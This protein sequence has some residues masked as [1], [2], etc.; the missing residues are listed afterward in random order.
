MGKKSCP[1]VI[2][3]FIAVTYTFT[4]NIDI[5][6]TV[7]NREGE[8]VAG[9][10]VLLKN[11]NLNTTSVQDGSY[12]IYYNSTAV[13][14]PLP[15]DLLYEAILNNNFI[16]FKLNKPE[17][18]TLSIY[19]LDGRAISDLHSGYLSKGKYRFAFPLQ[20]LSYQVY[21]LR[22]GIGT[23]I[24]THKIIPIMN[25]FTL[26]HMG[27]ESG[28][29]TGNARKI[30]VD[31]TLIVACDKYE[32]K[33]VPVSEYIT[34][35]DIVLEFDWSDFL[36]PDIIFQNKYTSF[37]EFTQ[38]F[39]SIE[40]TAKAIAYGV[41]RKL[42]RKWSES[43]KLEQITFILDDDPNTIGWKS[44]HPP[45]IT[46][47]V[48]GPYLQNYMGNDIEKMADEVKGIMWHEYTHGYQYDDLPNTGGEIPA[49]VEG[50]ADA[51]R[52]FAGYIPISMRRPGGSWTYAYKTSAFFIAWI[53][54]E[55][56][57]GDPEFLYKFNQQL[58]LDDGKEFAW[59]TAIQE[60]LGE[61]VS[62]VWDKYQDAI[63]IDE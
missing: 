55:Y 52:Y 28:N 7:L 23:D 60:I 47:C 62:A 41:C 29:S 20:K 6:G 11:M 51:V 37:S 5:N 31:D 36:E 42:Y 16:G 34:T 1:A 17:N 22:I 24:V 25:S 44:G 58:A 61:D 57:G 49:V 4:Q 9:A 32:G 40:D 13:V 54:E 26:S 63:S 59:Q 35:I 30:T 21:L 33:R 18:V 8:P 50:I 15:P 3:C 27:I 14:N 56:N 38:R 2:I 43:L 12:R 39:P 10:T 48:G 53:Q 19:T 45:K 46:I